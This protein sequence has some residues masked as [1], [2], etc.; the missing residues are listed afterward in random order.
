M[1]DP[2]LRARLEDVAREARVS[3][4]AA[5]YVLNG[6]PGVSD[7]TRDRV[8]EVASRL[9]YHHRRAPRGPLPGAV[10]GTLGAALSPTRHEGE[11]PN[12]YVAELLAGV[13]R[14]ARR[15]RYHVN[16]EM[17][18]AGHDAE[19]PEGID[20]MLFLG[21]AF[22][23]AA[24]ARIR[25][26][27]LLVGTSFPQV[28]LDAVLAD[29]R[30]GAYLATAHLL[31]G[32]R[33]RIALLNGPP[34]ATTT[35]SK[36]AGFQD[37]LWERELPSGSALA[38]RVEFTVGAGEAGAR[39]LLTG[40]K[41]PDAIVTGDDVIAIGVLNAAA[42]LGIRVPDDLAIVGFGDS[43]T[44]ALLRPALSSVHVFQ[45]EM[46]RLGVR[47]LLDRLRESS[48]S[49]PCVRSLVSPELVV[50]ESSAGRGSR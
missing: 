15:N 14:E 1:N 34:H 46:G 12:Y 28:S 20:G 48:E 9:G 32:G 2:A 47:R 21:G 4:A 31:D 41:V 36:Q 16:V 39:A 45:Q 19:V 13:E 8:L 37:A 50:R 10:A 6:R 30:L 5:S 7:G 18:T 43:P 49:T 44:G 40:P 29:N 23:P 25:I 11:T 26:P 35:N 38:V 3:K 24:L 22:D 27:A 33:R 42:D 17:W